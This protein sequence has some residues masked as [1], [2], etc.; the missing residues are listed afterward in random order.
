MFPLSTDQEQPIGR[1]F[2]NDSVYQR[3]RQWIIEGRLAPGTFLR[4]QELARDFGVSRTPVR[5]SLLRLEAEG[6]VVTKANRWTQVAPLDIAG[7]IRRYPLIWTLETYAVSA[8]RLDEWTADD[9]AQMERYNQQLIQ[10]I[11]AHDA[12]A[13]AQ[14]D[15]QFHRVFIDQAHNPE[16]TAV[17]SELK[18]PLTR[19]EI[20]Y[21]KEMW[22]SK[23]SLSEHDAILE[24]LR[25]R[26]VEAA[27]NAIE[28]NWKQSLVRIQEVM[29]QISA[30][31]TDS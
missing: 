10:A 28:T 17:L 9:F 25:S 13:A 8:T 16:L 11:H 31:Q 15:D 22:S 14:A 7:V 29:S 4:D 2:V 3:L 26:N 23:E 1:R 27:K 6:L 21:Y 20:A 12:A 18:M 30:H 24:A 5:E 19:V